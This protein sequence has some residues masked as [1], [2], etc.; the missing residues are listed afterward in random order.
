MRAA[1]IELTEQ[2]RATLRSWLAA[3]KTERRMAFR[4][5]VIL[6]VAEGLGNAAVAERLETRPATISKWR[7]R[8][9]R[10]RLVG[11]ADAPRSGKPRHYQTADE[12]RIL[13]ALD[14]PPP[15]GYGR[16]DGNL[17]AQ[18]LRELCPEGGRRGWAVF[19]TTGERCGVVGRREATYPS[20]GACPGLA[21]AAQWPSGHRVQPCLQAARHDDAVCRS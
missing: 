16:W 2:E 5:E 17:L 8:F 6:A 15:K 11:L 13:A 21:Q 9:A 1:A 4:A 14:E 7:G 12:T 10:N 19:A 3:G 20:A 18:H